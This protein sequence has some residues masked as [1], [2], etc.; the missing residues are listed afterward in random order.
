MNTFSRRSFFSVLMVLAAALIGGC[1][2]MQPGGGPQVLDPH[3]MQQAVALDDVGY[4]RSAVEA[5]IMSVNQGIPAMGYEAMPLIG[6]AA[7]NASI[8]T[9]R[10]LISAGADINARTPDGDTPVML[11]AYFADEEQGSMQAASRR[12]EQAVRML[13]E[14]GAELENWGNLY[15]PLGYAAYRGRDDTVRYLLGRGAR[16][17]ADAEGRVINVNTPLIMATMQGH[18]STAR[19]L[20][21]AGAD[22]GIRV[23][24]GMTAYEFARRHNHSHMLQ[25]LSCADR[26][27]PGVS[28]AQRCE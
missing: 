18:R 21:Q 2:G 6:F 15:T 19:Y 17:N 16:V 10:Y 5:R 12:Y 23:K 28:S 11:A 27:R 25:M 1:A 24:G 7:R 8:N 26:L 9:L 4:V 13:V 14:A 20:L 22:A 3:R